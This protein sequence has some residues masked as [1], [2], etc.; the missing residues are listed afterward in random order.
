VDGVLCMRFLVECVMDIG[1]E[2]S[3]GILNH[4]IFFL[5]ESLQRFRK[6]SSSMLKELP[7]STDNKCKYNSH[8]ILHI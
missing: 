1:Q 4:D 2:A 5:V 8:L 3:I 6:G 7:R